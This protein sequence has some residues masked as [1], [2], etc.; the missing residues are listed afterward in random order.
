[1]SPSYRM[2][3]FTIVHPLQYCGPANTVSTVDFLRPTRPYLKER[4]AT[5]LRNGLADVNLLHFFPSAYVQN[6]S[7]SNKCLA[8]LY[9]FLGLE[10]LQTMR[11][12]MWRKKVNFDQASRMVASRICKM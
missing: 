9:P 3:Y 4:N 8:G 11:H 1:M 12:K 10:Q 6:E 2:I 5:H 7:S